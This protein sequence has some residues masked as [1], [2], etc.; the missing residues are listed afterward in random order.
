MGL[1]A[2]QLREFVVRPALHAIGFHTLAAE[3]LVMG[4]AAQESHLK[5][6]R[7]LNGGPAVGLFQMEPTTYHDIWQN[8]LRSRPELAETILAAIDYGD[9]T[10][11]RAPGVSAPYPEPSRM[12]WDLRYAAIMCRVHYLRV[13]E[14]LPNALDVWGLA[15]YWKKYYNTVLGGG[16]AEEFVDNFGRVQ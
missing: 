1:N 10:A 11:V 6:V 5:F 9:L 2:N 4:T 15:D 14:V 16:T 13:R 8:F 7:Q 12:V 3:N